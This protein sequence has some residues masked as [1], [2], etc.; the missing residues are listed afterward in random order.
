[1]PPDNLT[2]NTLGVATTTLV[3]IETADSAFYSLP[4]KFTPDLPFEKI[5]L[6]ILCRV[7]P[8]LVIAKILG[9]FRIPIDKC[10]ESGG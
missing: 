4:S 7:T 8:L 9:V 3:L 10:V 2:S 5:S 1:M 6:F